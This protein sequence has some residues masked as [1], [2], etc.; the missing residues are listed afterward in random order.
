MRVEGTLRSLVLFDVAD[1]IHVDQIG[2]M[3]GETTGQAVRHFPRSA[4]EYVRFERPPVVENYA[5]GRIKYYDSGVVSVETNVA[6][7][8]TWEEL[9]EHSSRF[10][11]SP[12]TESQAIDLLRPRLER[13]RNALVNPYAQWLSEDYYIIVVNGLPCTAKQLLAF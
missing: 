5:E 2:A 9:V 7:S 8:G 12:H 6:F 3:L 13:A 1:A 4:P 10:V 11:A